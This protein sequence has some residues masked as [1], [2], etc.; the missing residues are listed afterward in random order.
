V[1]PRIQNGKQKIFFDIK[2]ENPDVEMEEVKLSALLPEDA[3][4]YID[5]SYLLFS[6]AEAVLDPE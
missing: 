4:N 3:Y 5:A 6:N 1:S 2:V